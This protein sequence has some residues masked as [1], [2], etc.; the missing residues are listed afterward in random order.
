MTQQEICD[1][2]ALGRQDW[3]GRLLFLSVDGWKF[4]LG[5]A[6]IDF[7]WWCTYRM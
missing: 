7:D 4:R 1:R 5:C 3:G 6:G 2:A